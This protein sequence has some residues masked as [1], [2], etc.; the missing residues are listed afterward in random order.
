MTA[1]SKKAFNF[2]SQAKAASGASAKQK[3]IG[4]FSIGDQTF[5]IVELA[6]A[7]IAYLVYD[8]E[9]EEGTKVVTTVLA[10]TEK[11]LTVDSAA[12]FK[13]LALGAPGVKGLELPEVIEVFEYV[14]QVV[15]GAIPPT[16]PAASRAR[17]RKTTS[18]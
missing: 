2:A 1:L 15:S 3:I 11:A 13:K 6:N 8:M 12:R 10:F 18:G 9:N 14:L 5:D 4:E 7:S 16:S 17:Q